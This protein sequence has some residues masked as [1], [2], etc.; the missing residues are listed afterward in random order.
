M[1]L[2]FDG[3]ILDGDMEI[4]IQ[5]L[6]NALKLY[7]SI[8]KDYPQYSD[9]FFDAVAKILNRNYEAPPSHSLESAHDD[10]LPF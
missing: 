1:I 4:P 8:L 9:A 5:S 2:N 3:R 6:E 10:E 7:Q